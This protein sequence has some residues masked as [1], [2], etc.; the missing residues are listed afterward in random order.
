LN[1][2][3]KGGDWSETSKGGEIEVFGVVEVQKVEDSPRAKIDV[4]KMGK[5]HDC[6]QVDEDG[7]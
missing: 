4:A 5:S 6:L 2:V 3:P 1:G 7:Y